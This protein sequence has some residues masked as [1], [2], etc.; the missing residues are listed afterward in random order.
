MYPDGVR[1]QKT[2]HVSTAN[3]LFG[4]CLGLYD[5]IRLFVILLAA[6]E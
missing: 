3:K 5:V 2:S 4:N 1:K 6:N